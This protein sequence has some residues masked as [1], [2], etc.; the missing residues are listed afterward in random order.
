MIKLYWIFS[1]HVTRVKAALEYKW[2]AYEHIS[3]DLRNKSKE[4]LELNPN[5]KI[6]VLED[7]D[8]TIVYESINIVLYL[9]QKYPNTYK[10]ISQDMYER[11]KQLHV[12]WII[13]NINATTLNLIIQKFTWSEPTQEQIDS[14][15]PKVDF[16]SEAILKIYDWKNFAT[17]TFSLADWSLLWMIFF[18]NNFMPQ[19]VHPK[20]KEWFDKLSQLPE[21][22]RIFPE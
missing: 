20:L 12:V 9:D 15:K 19:F 17:G 6:P 22:K 7:E 16:L 5:W 18:F 4:F 21:I 10:M 8:G 1:P 11:I 14:V 3:V 13:D 2:L